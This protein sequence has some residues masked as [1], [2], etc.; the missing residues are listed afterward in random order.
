MGQTS[1]VESVCQVKSTAVDTESTYEE[2]PLN[3]NEGKALPRLLGD[4]VKSVEKSPAKEATKDSSEHPEGDDGLQ[5]CSPNTS[6]HQD[7]SSIIAIFPISA[8]SATTLGGSK[9]DLQEGQNSKALR[10]LERAEARKQVLPFLL[11]NGFQTVKSKKTWLWRSYYPLH[12]AV[13]KKDIETVRLLLVAGADTQKQNHKSET[14]QQLAQRLNRSGSHEEIIEAL[15]NAK[16][17][18]TKSSRSRSMTSDEG[19]CSTSTATEV[20]PR[21]I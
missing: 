16:V 17:R 15:R 9:E 6:K 10:K 7:A 20:I 1:C 19:R 4:S 11:Q 18:K 3:G 13:K 2:A 8:A 21:G 5:A 12:V 14:P